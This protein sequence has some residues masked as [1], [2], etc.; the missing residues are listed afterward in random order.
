MSVGSLSLSSSASESCCIP[1]TCACDTWLTVFCDYE[2]VTLDY[3]GK[4][5]VF[6]L[7]RSDDMPITS[8]NPQAG[9]MSQDRIFRLS[10]LERTVSVGIGGT[11]TDADGTEW[12]IYRVE[13]LKA[14]CVKK[15]SARSVAACFQLLDNIDI[16]GEDCDC[17]DC[18]QV[19]KYKRLARVKGKILAEAGSLTAR[20]DSRDLVYQ[21]TGDLVRWPIAVK[22]TGQHRLKDRNGTYRIVRVRDHGP[23]VPFM[24]GLEMDSAD[25]SV[26][27][28]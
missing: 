21:Y 17:Q 18:G 6:G 3:C 14:F 4:T 1:S 13:T 2:R 24:V 12:V 22:P 20:N 9:V 28:S 10:M 25:C 16:F 26:R 19:V 23:F 15:V 11:I 27:G 7:A 8:V 5:T